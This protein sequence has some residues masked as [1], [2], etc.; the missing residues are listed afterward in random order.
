M[1]EGR[2]GEGA[3]CSL[4]GLGEQLELL[5][6]ERKRVSYLFLYN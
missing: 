2:G 1:V 6:G 3:E 5:V 4:W